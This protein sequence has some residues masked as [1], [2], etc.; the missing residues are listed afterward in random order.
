MLACPCQLLRL[1]VYYTTMA[2]RIDTPVASDAPARRGVYLLSHPRSASN[3]FQRMMEKQPGFQISK[4]KLHDSQASLTQLLKGRLSEWSD[5]EREALYDMFR[6][7]FDKVQDE[8]A[9]ARKNGNQLFMKDHTMFLSG[10][11]KLF[12]R[13]FDGDEVDPLVVYERNAPKSTQTNPT[14][15]PDSLL[16][17][18]QPIFQIRHPVLMFPS[19]LRALIKVQGR[20]RPRD[21]SV[22]PLLTLRYSRDLFDWYLNHGGEVKPKVIDADDIINDRAVVRQLCIETGMDPDAVQYEWEIRE[23]KD[24]HQ[25]IMRSTINASTCIIPGLVAR[26]LDFEIE[27]VKWKAEFGEEDGEDLAMAVHDAM[28]DYNYLLTHRV[29]PGK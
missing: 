7:G 12:A 18:M 14:S 20:A 10:P 8:L 11:D 2:G 3:L 6:A 13:T 26:G 9:D 19:M 21:L 4:Y 5:E 27:K 24:P 16:L 22:T 23:D 25:A 17:S 28:P 15:M 1:I 29:L